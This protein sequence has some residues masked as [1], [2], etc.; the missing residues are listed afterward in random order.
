MASHPGVCLILFWRCI[1]LLCFPVETQFMDQIALPPVFETPAD[2]GDHCCQL[3][4]QG[5]RVGVVPTMG[6]LH[7]GHLSL[8]EL[9]RQH[10]DHVVA[11]VFVNPTQFAPHEDF[12]RYPRDLQK[13]LALLQSVGVDAVYAPATVAMYPPDYSTTIQAPK[14]ASDWEGELRPGH[15][16]GVATVV[17][18]LLSATR[19]DVAVFGQ[20]DYQQWAVISQM[21]KD[22][23]LNTKII[24]APIVRQPDGLAMSSRNRYLDAEQRTRALALSRALESV[25]SQVNHGATDARELAVTLMQDL[26]DGGVDS[27]D[28][29]V[30]VD[31]QNL[32]V[33]ET[34][35]RPAVA[36]VAAYVG[37]TRLIDNKVLHVI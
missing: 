35:D 8:V 9:C 22:L 19:A 31:A 21:V 11:T 2:I 36:L 6:A 14:I 25:Q 28:Y 32:S 30:I 26:I 10:C 4:R 27:V 29:A 5:A 1:F 20:K 18:K 7:L 23:N 12:D 3:Q 37:N 15:F 17:L 33:L 34:I 13:D 24:A 16:Q